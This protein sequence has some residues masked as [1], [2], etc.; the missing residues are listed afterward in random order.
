MGSHH[1]KT[2]EDITAEWMTWTLQEGGV[3]RHSAVCQ[4]EI[5]HIGGGGVG[6]LSG[7]ARVQL[8]YDKPKSDLPKSVVVKLSTA[9]PRN[10][11][12]GDSLNA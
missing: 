7:V 3:C 10:R 1:P 8:T 9:T 12:L 5:T 11:E 6:Y 2:I 4:I